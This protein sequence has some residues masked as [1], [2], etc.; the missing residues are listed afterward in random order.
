MSKLVVAAELLDANEAHIARGFLLSNG[1]PAV[2]FDQATAAV[3]WHLSFAL[4]GL[5]LM[6]PGEF[7]DNSRK[8]LANGP[9]ADVVDGDWERCPACQSTNVFRP[10]SILAGLACLIAGGIPTAVVTNRRHCQSC[11]EDWTAENEPELPESP[12]S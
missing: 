6:V 1:I 7:L 5:R 3:G 9:S 10:A 11:G 2:V 12:R 8:L 4:Q